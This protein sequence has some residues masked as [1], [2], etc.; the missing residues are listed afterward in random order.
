MHVDFDANGIAV[1]QTPNQ[2]CNGR[3][4]MNFYLAGMRAAT[5]Y[6]ARH[7]IE[8]LMGTLRGPDVSFT[9]G[10]VTMR[11]P[12]AAS[13]STG[14]PEYR[15]VL[16]QSIINSNPIATDLSGNL[17][18]YGPGG[19]S[20]LTRVGP[21]GTFLGIFEDGS[22]DPSW[23]MVREFDLAGITIAE[24][25]AQRVN[26]QLIA[27]G[28]HPVTSF[29]HEAI[30]LPDGRYLL[31]A[32][33]ERTLKNVQGQDSIDLLGDTIL[34]LDPDLKVVWVWDSFNHLDPNRAAVLGETCS[35]PA[36]LAC[37]A[38]YQ[39]S[40]ASDWLHGNALQLTPDGNI[41]Y[42]IRHQDWVVKIDYRNGLGDG[43]VLWRIGAGGDFALLDG[44]DSLW[45]SHQHDAHILPDGVSLLLFDNGNTRA[46]RYPDQGNSRGQLWRID[47]QAHTAK[48]V[49]NADLRVNSSALGTAQLLPNGNYHFDA[50]FVQNPENPTQRITEALEVDP[51]GSIAWGMKSMTQQYRSFRL[52]NLYTPPME[53]R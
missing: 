9:S 12:E 17:I 31:L 14:V 49:V 51:N 28:I 33:S 41:L 47:E 39:A 19:L 30:H 44:D 35:Y 50:G 52:D 48:L 24:T 53:G 18:W 11:A 7:T 26:D 21:G 3:S 32:G 40:Q 13:T 20:L 37:S 5:E 25:N 43:H 1:V 2:D 45:F 23:Q 16:L 8:S 4:S 34:V 22:K 42:S 38:F 36:S 46:Q 29:H 6:T 10:T 27:M 15:A